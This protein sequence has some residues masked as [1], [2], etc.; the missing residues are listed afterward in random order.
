M[1]TLKLVNNKLLMLIATLRWLA[2]ILFS[3]Y[4]PKFERLMIHCQ[5][6]IG[7]ETSHILYNIDLAN[8]KSGAPLSF[9]I[10]GTYSFL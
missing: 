4:H 8:P 3:P 9:I 6:S 2:L 1:P 10:A 7:L 5:S